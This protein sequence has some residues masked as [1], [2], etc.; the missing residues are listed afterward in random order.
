[1]VYSVELFPEPAAHP[2]SVMGTLGAVRLHN[3]DCLLVFVP[4]PSLFLL[5][6]FLSPLSL[7]LSAALFSVHLNYSVDSSNHPNCRLEVCVCVRVSRLHSR[8]SISV[9]NI[10]FRS[11]YLFRHILNEYTTCIGQCIVLSKHSLCDSLHL[12]LGLQI[13]QSC[14]DLPPKCTLVRE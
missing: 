5:L 1:M 2:T 7:S 8:L 11:S 9:S 6:L 4:F 12:H 10:L 14:I 13:F 3:T